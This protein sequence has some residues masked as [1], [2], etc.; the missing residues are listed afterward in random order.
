MAR[1]TGKQLAKRAGLQLNQALY[2]KTGDW[3]HILK[4]FPG[5]LFDDYGYL[6]FANKEEYQSFAAGTQAVQVKENPD[7]NTLI[8]AKGIASHPDY[9]LLSERGE[10]PNEVSS[11]YEII[12]GATVRVTV[13]R[14]ERDPSARKACLRKW[15]SACLVCE[16]DFG[17]TYGKIGEGFIHVHHLRPI[18]SIKVAYVLIPERDLRPVCPNCHAMLHRHDPPYS[19]E[20]LR[21]LLGNSA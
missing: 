8:V 15:G 2:R 18:S 5:A 7:T 3:Y 11:Q 4:R 14:Y 20:E 6:L 9:L 10:F 19:I 17:D 21:K 13:N 16:F 12:E 1:V